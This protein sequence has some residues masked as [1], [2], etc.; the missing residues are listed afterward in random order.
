V[1]GWDGAFNLEDLGGIALISGG[2]TRHGRV[3]RS[4]A[5]EYLTELGWGDAVAAD[6]S[7]VVD[8]RNPTEVRREAH[9][10]IVSDASVEGIDIVSCPTEDPADPEFERV[11]LPW[12]D[13]PRSY[14]DNLAMYPDKFR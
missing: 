14:G 11:L 13:H 3:Y 1:T 4:G 2:T 5:R 7:T 10:P 9:H 8:L 12:L 6:V